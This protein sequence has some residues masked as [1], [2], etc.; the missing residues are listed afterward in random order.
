M[1]K[2]KNLPAPIIDFI[3]THHGNSKVQYFYRS[4]LN[5]Y[6]EKEIEQPKNVKVVESND[7]STAV[8]NT[9]ISAGALA[10][11][12][13]VLQ[14]KSK[15]TPPSKYPVQYAMITIIILSTT[16]TLSIEKSVSNK[17]QTSQKNI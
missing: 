13:G 1:A 11:I 10:L 2:R 7:Y 3:R 14:Y 6:P 15:T 8:R 5:K 9:L 16:F 12:Y 4:Y 17:L